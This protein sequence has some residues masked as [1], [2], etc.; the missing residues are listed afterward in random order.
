LA[1]R[2]ASGIWVSAYLARLRV[3]AIPVYVTAHG[4]EVGGAVIVKLATLDGQA[5]AFQRITDPAT[6]GRSWDVLAEGGESA[7]DA[8]IARARARDRDLWVIE[9]EDRQGRALL[10]EGGL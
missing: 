4:D 7:V 6:G 10:E 9:V 1:P 3:A 8:V 2:L 5:R